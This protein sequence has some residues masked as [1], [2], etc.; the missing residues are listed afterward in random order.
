MAAG[1][2]NFE[3]LVRDSAALI[4]D[5]D[6]GGGPI[7]QRNLAQLDAASR[8]LAQSHPKATDP[9]AAAQAYVTFRFSTIE[10]FTLF[11]KA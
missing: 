6:A 3:K 11:V 5:I 1:A 8:L 2:K 10:V 9:Q 7:L 4:S